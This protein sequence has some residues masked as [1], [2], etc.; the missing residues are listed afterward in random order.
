MSFAGSCCPAQIRK[1]AVKDR[2]RSA[3]EAG[4]CYVMLCGHSYVQ[5]Q[6][7]DR[8]HSIRE[9]L[10]GAGL[11]IDDRQVDFRAGMVL[12]KSSRLSLVTIDDEVPPGTLDKMT[13]KVQEAPSSVTEAIV[14]QVLPGLPYED[15]RRLERFSRGF[16][17]IAVLVAQA[18]S[19]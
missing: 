10:R 13:Y 1:G 17:K 9:T 14:E 5:R 2:V 11:T 18:W 12:R 16:P 15:Q 4:G 8:E 3:V 7:E 19:G 6:I